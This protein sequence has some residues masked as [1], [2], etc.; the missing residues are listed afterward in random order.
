MKI[1]I[2]T[3]ALMLLTAGAVAQESSNLTWRLQIELVTTNRTIATNLTAQLAGTVRAQDRV[4]PEGKTINVESRSGVNG[5]WQV[6]GVYILRD[7]ST[8]TNIMAQ[9]DNR[10]APQIRGRVVLHLCPM[11]GTIKDWAGCDIDP[12]A[13]YQR[14]SW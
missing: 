5:E 12:R 9:I 4:D 1:L 7:E 14:A 2:P 11:E 3:I 13:R 10:R 6:I 8:A